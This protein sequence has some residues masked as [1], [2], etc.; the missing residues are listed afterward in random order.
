MTIAPPGQ[1]AE[2][3][4]APSPKNERARALALPSATALVT[5]QGRRLPVK[6]Q[7]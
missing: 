1:R 2:Q 3:A 5:P 7:Q 6:E 4:P